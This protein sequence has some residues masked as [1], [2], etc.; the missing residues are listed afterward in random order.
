MGFSVNKILP[1]FTDNYLSVKTASEISGYNRQYIRRLL[2]S[3]IFR[4]RKVGQIWF[5]NLGDF[6]NYL[7]RAKISQDKRF[8]PSI[9]P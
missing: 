6:N 1:E 9:N 3:G 2:R 8:G 7:E 5:I 4:S